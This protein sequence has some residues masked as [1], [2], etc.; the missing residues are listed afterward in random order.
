MYQARW[1]FFRVNVMKKQTSREKKGQGLKE[2]G[3]KERGR[4]A[5]SVSF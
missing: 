3:H 1:D 4:Q 2:Q 5:S